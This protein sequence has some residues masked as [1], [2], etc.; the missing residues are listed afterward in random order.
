M[1]H[2]QSRRRPRV[3][4]RSAFVAVDEHSGRPGQKH[5]IGVQVEMDE[6]GLLVRDGMQAFMQVCDN[7][8]G[9][10]A[11]SMDDVRSDPAVSRRGRAP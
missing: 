10:E 3:V 1:S 8:R 6:A 4:R 9:R 7:V 2:G 5:V 11:G